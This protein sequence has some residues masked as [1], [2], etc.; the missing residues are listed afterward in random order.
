M[1]ANKEATLESRLNKLKT[2]RTISESLYNDI[3]DDLETATT[4]NDKYLIDK[5]TRLIVSK[6]KEE[7]DFQ[8][9]KAIIM[10]D[11][12]VKVTETPQSTIEPV[13]SKPK[14]EPVI[15]EPIL[16]SVSSINKHNLPNT[17]ESINAHIKKLYQEIQEIKFPDIS[18]LSKYM[19][20]IEEAI[21]KL[22]NS[23]KNKLE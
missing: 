17:Q 11:N 4:L 10:G 21:R 1:S 23:N 18:T 7:M 15:L 13:P 8:A 22:E 12:I 19:S 14:L 2:D 16:T 3:K 9:R 5:V 20:N 6:E